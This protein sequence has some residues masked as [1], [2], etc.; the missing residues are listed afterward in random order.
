LTRK[1]GN[2]PAGTYVLL[3]SIYALLP[4]AY[5]IELGTSSAV[6]SDNV[7]QHSGSFV[8]QGYL[9]SPV[10]GL[11]DALPTSFVLTPADA[12][13]TLSRYD[14]TSYAA[15]A[16]TQ[17]NLFGAPK[18]RVELDAQTVQFNLLPTGTT[19]D[20]K[21][22]IR[23]NGSDGGRSGG[24]FVTGGAIEVRRDDQAAA[25]DMISLSQADVAR[26]G[27]GTLVLGASYDLNQVFIDGAPAGWEVRLGHKF[28]PAPY[29]VVV[30]EGV[31]ITAGDVLLVGTNIALET[32]ATINGS[33]TIGG[34]LSDTA[35]PI[36]SADFS[37]L[38][39]LPMAGFESMMAP[40]CVRTDRSASRHRAIRFWAMPN[41]RHAI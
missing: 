14:E 22:D 38:T 37:V 39:S 29:D 34:A 17:A 9:G 8:S 27:S 28:K 30:R 25:T 26:L 31:T 16:A 40:D 21:G 32:G 5:R 3:P 12:V 36:R 2:L 11:R 10:A 4:G 24:I 7:A 33:G 41:S 35:Y 6:D 15:F 1:T 19:F 20:F 18:P 23:L 13:R